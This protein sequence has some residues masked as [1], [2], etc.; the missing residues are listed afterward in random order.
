MPWSLTL[1]SSLRTNFYVM[2]YYCSA[3]EWR[4]KFLFLFLFFSLIASWLQ[5][6]RMISMC[7]HF[8]PSPTHSFNLSA[9][10]MELTVS[11]PQTVFPPIAL[12]RAVSP[13]IL[14]AGAH[15][16]RYLLSLLSGWVGQRVACCPPTPGRG[17]SVMALMRSGADILSNQF[18]SLYPISNHLFLFFLSNDARGRGVMKIVCLI[19]DGSL[20]LPGLLLQGGLVLCD[21]H[22]C[23]NGYM[24]VASWQEIAFIFPCVH[25]GTGVADK[26]QCAN[27]IISQRVKTTA[28]S[29]LLWQVA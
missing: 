22:Q 11:Q 25:C 6:I 13:G 7:E 23:I 18:S 24:G 14:S 12:T 21:I 2:Q 1:L 3:S 10:C 20:A 29:D 26:V 4:M 15:T 19:I 27:I 28:C 16:G 17:E 5:D 8:N 9:I